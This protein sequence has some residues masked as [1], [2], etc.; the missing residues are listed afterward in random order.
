MTAHHYFVFSALCIALGSMFL[1]YKGQSQIKWRAVI[2]GIL[3]I[4]MLTYL[5]LYPVSKI[6]IPGELAVVNNS[7]V[8]VQHV[9]FKE[10]S[11]EVSSKLERIHKEALELAKQARENE[12]PR[13][14]TKFRATNFKDGREV[15]AYWKKKE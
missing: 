6:K 1:E 10:V 9:A 14:G 8:G 2:P 4:L 11:S 13:P 3:S 15:A 12:G 5:S 7:V